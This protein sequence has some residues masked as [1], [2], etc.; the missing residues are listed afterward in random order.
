MLESLPTLSELLNF[1]ISS[2]RTVNVV[3]QIGKHYSALGKLLLNDHT[4]GITAAIVY[5]HQHDGAKINQEILTQWLHGKGKKPLTWSTLI[6]VL[7]VT[8]SPELATDIGVSL[9]RAQIQEQHK[10]MEVH[11]Q[12]QHKKKEAIMQLEQKIR[13]NV[14]N[15]LMQLCL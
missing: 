12:E 4:G 9:I 10:K 14:Q 8:G 3:E 5:Q 13:Q 7:K 15:S 11:R 1:K 2:S 6:D